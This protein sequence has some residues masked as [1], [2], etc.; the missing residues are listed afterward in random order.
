MDLAKSCDYAI[1]GLL[2]LAQRPD[3]FQPVLL[4]DIAPHAKA[5]AAYLSKVFQTLRASNLVRSHRGRERGYSLARAPQA[6]SLYD[7]IIALEGPAALRSL[8]PLARQA[9]DGDAFRRVWGE[10]EEKIVETMRNTTLW[11]I[12]TQQPA[13]RA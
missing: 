4:R 7:V 10:I 13:G 6:V 1:R 5:P 9:E 2:Y 12:L 3:P 11:T 8:P